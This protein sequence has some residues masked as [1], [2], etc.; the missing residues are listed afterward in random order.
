MTEGMKCVK[1]AMFCCQWCKARFVRTFRLSVWF[2]W[3]DL[4]M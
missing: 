1:S 2:V 4:L 3:C